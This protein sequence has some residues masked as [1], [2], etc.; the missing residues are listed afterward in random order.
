MPPDSSQM[1]AVI[2]ERYGPPEQLVF[3]RAPRPK[4]RADQVL[5]MVHAAGIN[6]VDWRIRNGSLRWISPARFPLILG[7]DVAG[8]IMEVGSAASCGGWSVGDEV[9]GF[10]KLKEPGGYAEFAAAACD[11]IAPKPRNATFVEAAA[12]PLAGTTALQALRDVAQVSKGDK[13]LVNGASGGVGTFAV[14]IAVAF[15]AHVTAVCSAR[16]AAL[17]TELGAE[18]VIDY[19]QEDFTAGDARYNVVLDAVGYS[20]FWAC[21]RILAPGGYYINT[22][23]TPSTML[24]HVLSRLGG[25]QCRFI[26]AKPRGE[27]LRVLGQLIEEGGVRPIIDTVYSLSEAAAAH[28]TSEAGRTRGK[29][30]LRVDTY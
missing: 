20:S 3:G 27:D 2:L 21:R 30:V 12:V 8:V 11:V 7:F 19:T 17:V 23:P 5:L 1:S 18:R 9:F 25:R 29:L 26:L 14:Q 22:L 24:F 16:N 15:G 6:P 4:I 28:R 13:V 10:L